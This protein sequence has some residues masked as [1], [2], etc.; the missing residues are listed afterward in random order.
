MSIHFD[1]TEKFDRARRQQFAAALKG[2]SDDIGFKVSSRGWCY[3]MEQKGFISKNQFSK[4]DNAINTCRKEGLLPVDFVAEE[5]SREFEGVE[6]PTEGTV[7]GTL[8]W[9]LR[10]VLE[11]AKYYTPDWWNGEEY[12]IQMVV[13]KID[14]V[15]LFGPICR[16]YHIPI[17]NSKGWS[18]I[19]QRAEYAR[20][21]KQA[22]DDGLKCVL[23]YCG[24]HDPDGLR[25]S[26]TLRTNLEQVKDVTWEDGIGGYDPESLEIHRFGLNFDFIQKHK[27]SWINNLI[28]GN[29]NKIMDLGSPEHKNHKLPYVQSYLKQ[30]GRR[31]CEANAIVVKPTEARRLCRSE[32][33]KWL[34]AD[35]KARFAERREEVEKRYQDV[36]DDAGLA[37]AITEYLDGNE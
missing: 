27:L 7:N 9:M 13:E 10:D 12:Y 26:D 14:L 36:L 6:R 4:V 18:S 23:L 2:I 3:I 29:T 25:I 16:E 31:K 20:R 19:L 32:I 33:E 21:F 11:G 30:I 35:A 22:E 24:D 5:K 37:A 28:T 8:A 17:A 15:Q 1:F 34:G